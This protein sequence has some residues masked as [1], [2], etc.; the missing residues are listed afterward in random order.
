MKNVRNTNKTVINIDASLNDTSL[1]SYS[2]SGSLTVTWDPASALFAAPITSRIQCERIGDMIFIKIQ[3]IVGSPANQANIISNVGVVP[4]EFR[5][6]SNQICTAIV[7]NGYL[8]DLSPILQIA[9][10]YNTYVGCA[11]LSTAGTL[12][13]GPSRY[14]AFGPVSIDGTILTL[15]QGPYVCGLITQTLCFSYESPSFV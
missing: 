3:G 6:T 5:P 4:V 13:F 12:S 10:P 11:I 8:N 2:K 7:V 14:P 1:A 9:Q 15:F